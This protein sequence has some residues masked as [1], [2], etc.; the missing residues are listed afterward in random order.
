LWAKGQLKKRV[1]SYSSG[2][3]SCNTGWSGNNHP[4]RRIFLNIMEK[5]CLTG[6]GF[7]RQKNITAGVLNK[8]I[9]EF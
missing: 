4:L 7:T 6:T 8:V 5:G 3:D 9:G 2:V 1:K